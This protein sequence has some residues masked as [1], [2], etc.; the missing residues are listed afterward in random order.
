MVEQGS[1][2]VKIGDRV[3][4]E[5]NFVAPILAQNLRINCRVDMSTELKK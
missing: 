5:L 3:R 1:E 4:E 2:K